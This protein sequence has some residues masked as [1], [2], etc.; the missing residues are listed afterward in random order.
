MSRRCRDSLQDT[1]TDDKDPLDPSGS[2]SCCRQISS[3]GTPCIDPAPIYGSISLRDPGFENHIAETGGGAEGDEIPG[4]AAM[5]NLLEWTDG[6]GILPND[7]HGWECQ[8]NTLLPDFY[9]VGQQF[10]QRWW[11][12]TVNPKTGTYHARTH[13]VFDNT[14]PVEPEFVMP[15]PLHAIGFWACAPSPANS[16]RRTFTL[17]C[18]FGDLITIRLQAMYT[19]ISME[20]W[21]LGSSDPIV[22]GVTIDA[23]E[24]A[25][26]QSSNLAHSVDR[27][28]TSSYAPYEASFFMGQAIGG[29]VKVGITGFTTG[30]PPDDFVEIAIDVDDFSV[31][32]VPVGSNILLC[33]FASLITIDNST[34]E[35]DFL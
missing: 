20:S 10:V 30:L 28:L 27:I 2:S 12:D 15:G 23:N 17:K 31:D 9:S 35:T 8:H 25:A 13:D 29:L 22:P 14:F 34:T 4:D 24:F 19:D 11:V 18:G 7:A 5:T 33:A 3:G 6:E 26:D 21:E 1:F 32:L 16:Q